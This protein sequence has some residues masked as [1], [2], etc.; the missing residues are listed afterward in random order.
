MVKKITVCGSGAFGF[1][2]AKHLGNKFLDSQDYEI[3][4]YDKVKEVIEHIIQTRKHPFHFPNAM[5]PE[6]VQFATEIKDAV[7]DTYIL[8]LAVP[9][10][11]IGQVTKSIKGVVRKDSII[12]NVSKSLELKTNR[13]LSEIIKENLNNPIATF[14]GG[15]IAEDL[16]NDSY[17]GAEVGCEDY[18]IASELA[19]ILTTEHLKVYPNNDLI[20]VEYAGAFKNVISIIAGIADG[21]KV[22]H[23]SKTYL[24]TQASNEVKKIA[25]KLGAKEH[26]FSSGSHS[27]TNDLWMSCTGNT[28]NRYFGELIGKGHKPK[29]ALNILESEHKIAEGFYATKAAH[30]ILKKHSLDLPLI[31]GI[32]QVLYGNKDPKRI[33]ADLKT[34]S[35]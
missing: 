4:L 3:F 25:I 33:N 22:P 5:L 12:L 15:T 20:G 19:E 16:V 10:K 11:A 21:L 32:Y 27:W 23:G 18:K 7:K 29:E 28:R 31:E 9:S 26:T 13:R 17:L 14:S 30:Q 2:L 8:L 34:T 35:F 24:I 6:N 1:A